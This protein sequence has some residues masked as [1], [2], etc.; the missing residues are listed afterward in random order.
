MFNRVFFII[1]PASGKPEPIL[2][3]IHRLF[4]DTDIRWDVGILQKD[5]VESV[6][7]RAER[8]GAEVV[9]AYG[10]DGTQTAVAKHIVGRD[11]PL[12]ILPGGTANVMTLELDIPGTLEEACGMLLA[13]EPRF[14]AIDLGRIN[15]CCFLSKVTVGFGSRIIEQTS[16]ETKNRFGTMAYIAQGIKNLFRLERIHIILDIDGQT[17]ETEAFSCMVT[18][19]GNLGLRNLNLEPVDISD[20]LLDVFIIQ[21]LGLKSLHALVSDVI[22]EVP[23]EPLLHWR[24]KRVLLRTEPAEAVE[25]DGEMLEAEEY[26]IT[27]QEQAVR[28]LVGPEKEEEAPA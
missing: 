5:N 1:N 8:F 20:G 22:R 19:S 13:E 16:Q 11:L 3:T 10:G 28:V 17:V 27:V 14:R 24:G 12:A 21:D 6:I 18:N 23:Q 7:E 26:E 4:K 25:Y 15:D 9:A 2:N